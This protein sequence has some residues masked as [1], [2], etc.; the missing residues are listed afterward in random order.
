MREPRK[1]TS[2]IGPMISRL[3]YS[4]TRRRPAAGLFDTPEEIEA[5]LDL[6][7]RW[8]AA[9]HIRS[10]K[11]TDPITPLL[12]L[13]ANSMMRVVISSAPCSVPSDGRTRERWAPG[14][15]GRRSPLRT[16]K[17]NA[18]SGTTE[19]GGVMITGDEVNG[20]MASCALSVNGRIETDKRRALNRRNGEMHRPRFG[21][22]KYR[23]ID[24]ELTI[25]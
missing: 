2:R 18:M 23:A 1:P 6:L 19:Q 13:S 21:L 9:V 17:A 14:H 11:P 8:R 4:A 5:V 7:D 25:G 10:A 24:L 22:P 3:R 16:A 12:T 20:T 15:G